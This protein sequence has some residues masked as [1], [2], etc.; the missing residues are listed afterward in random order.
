MRVLFPQGATFNGFEQELKVYLEQAQLS[1]YALLGFSIQEARSGKQHRPDGI[2]LLDNGIFVCLEAKAYTG[3]WIGGVNTKWLCDGQE[4]KSSGIN[5]YDQAER[6]TLVIKNRLQLLL[7][8]TRFWVYSLIVAPDRARFLV[9]NASINTLKEGRAICVS[10]LSQLEYV[11]SQVQPNPQIYDKVQEIGLNRLVSELV[12]IPQ[13]QLA[14]LTTGTHPPQPLGGTLPSSPRPPSTRSGPLGRPAAQPVSPTEK[15]A[16]SGLTLSGRAPQQSRNAPPTARYARRRIPGLGQHMGMMKLTVAALV[17]GGVVTL[18]QHLWHGRPCPQPRQVRVA[19]GCYKDLTQEP[20]VIGVL[21]PPE[22][23]RPLVS[24]L[25]QTLG[26]QAKDVVVEGGP[27]TTY[28]EAQNAIA[29]Q[30]WDLVF[31]YSPMNSLRAKDN[32]Y[33][34]VGRMFPNSP[35]TYQS[36]L[37]V[38]AN[39]PIQTLNDITPRT[40]VALG[41]FGSASSFYVPAYD[42]YGKSFK[43]LVGHRGRDII[44]L[45]ATGRADVGAAVYGSV[46]TDSRFRV[47]HVSRPIPGSGVYLS[48]AL[49]P[50]LQQQLQDLLL[51]APQSLREE[52]NFGSGTEPE[53]DT[54]R[55]ISLRSE[56]VLTCADFSR[57]PVQFFCPQASTESPI[58]EGITGKINGFTLLPGEQVRLRLEQRDGQVCQVT[59]PLPLLSQVPGGTSPGTINRKQVVLRQVEPTSSPEGGCAMTLNA[60]HQIRVINSNPL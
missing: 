28:Q 29:R 60:P 8:K 37:F 49:A 11:L 57:S 2:V 17:L 14:A 13:S 41:D 18:G 39:S 53:Y 7:G 33:Q 24:Y 30:T 5:P 26:T 50:P 59:I 32:G 44:D 4:I 31:A 51:T 20:L 52:A 23:Y 34:W 48:P 19:G 58:P 21:T 6:Y 38:R 9:S 54:L 43:A 15:V 16:P 35:T 55:A 12:G 42:L 25:R 56:E 40:R 46:E 3:N 47:I 45:V 1:G 36:A 10:H 22:T 27:R